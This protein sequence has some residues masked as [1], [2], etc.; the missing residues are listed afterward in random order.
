MK[1]FTTSI[2]C[3]GALILTNPWQLALAFGTVS[4]IDKSIDNEKKIK[5]KPDDIDKGKKKTGH[6][7][8]GR[9]GR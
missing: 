3:I 2:L 4:H 9:I 8:F 6:P 1:K 5:Q 7:H